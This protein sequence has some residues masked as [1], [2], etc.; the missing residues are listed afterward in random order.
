LKLLDFS[1]KYVVADRI[2]A[3]EHGRWDNGLQDWYAIIVCAG[4][5]RVETNVPVAVAKK[6]IESSDQPT[7]PQGEHK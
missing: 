2:C 7:E 6:L 1:G 4:D 5:T 3:I